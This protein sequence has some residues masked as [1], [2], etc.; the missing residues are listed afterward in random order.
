MTIGEKLGEGSA[1]LV[2]GAGCLWRHDPE[3]IPNVH[4][5]IKRYCHNLIV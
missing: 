5:G 3:M 4:R 1:Q 2:G